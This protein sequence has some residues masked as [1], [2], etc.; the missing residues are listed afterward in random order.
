LKGSHDTD[1]TAVRHG[2]KAGSVTLG[3]RRVPV[4]RPRVR[5]AD[6]A[7]EVAVPTHDL[8]S[9]TDLLGP[10]VLD[11]M[12]A[13]LSTRCYAAGLEPD[14][15]QVEA[16][17]RSTAKSAASRR[18]VA[19]TEAALG[20][21]M[22][23][24]LTD[25]DLVAI[26]IDGVHFADHLC[27]VALGTGI[28][29]TK[30]PLGLVKGDT[31]NTTVVTDLL[32]DLS[33]RGMDT[34]R[35]ILAVL[36]GAKALTAAVNAVFDHPVIQRCQFHKIRNVKRYLPDP[37]AVVVATKCAPRTT[38]PTPCKPKPHCKPWRRISTR[39]IRVRPGRC[40]TGRGT[41]GDPPRGATNTRSHLALDE[42]DRVDDRDRSRSLHQRETLA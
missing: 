6:R 2:T 33:G 28:D 4:R 3:G 20:E 36:D 11:E 35:P 16:T 41:H 12:M 25:V 15:A 29:G 22:V 26:M 13:K 24:D 14:G 7:A 10:L 5:T 32:A 1:R 42:P 18:F 30:H 21:L 37:R 19:A 8:F 38:T 17:A 40:A 34:I 27:V 31:E 23:A 39:P 9:S